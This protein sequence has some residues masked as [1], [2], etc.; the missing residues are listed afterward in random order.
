MINSVAVKVNKGLSTCLLIALI[1]ASS[2]TDAQNNGVKEPPTLTRILFL[3][4]ASNSMYGQWQSGVKIDVAKKLLGQLLDSIQ[5]I[6][7]LDL[8]LR[9]YGHQ[10]AVTPQDCDDTKLEVPFSKKNAQVI[11]KRLYEI[12]PKGTTPIARSLQAAANDFPDNKSRNIILLITD[13]IEACDGDPCAISAALQ[14]KGIFLKPFV[15]GLGLDANYMKGFDCIGSI[16]DAST[17][18]GFKNILNVI[19]SQALNATTLQINL[20]DINNKANETNLSMTFYDQSSGNIR[21]NFVHTM[22]DKGFPDTL[23]I[24][25]IPTYRIVVHSIPEVIK[26]NVKLLAG[27]HNTI[28]ISTPQGNLMLKTEG[29]GDFKKLPCIVKK[30][31]ECIQL[32]VQEF[33]SSE[34]YLVGKYDLDV[35]SLPRTL[36]KGIEI[37]QNH[38]T[39]VQ[40]PA[41][42]LAT[43]TTTNRGFGSLYV[44]D[45]TGLLWVTNLDENAINFN[46]SL[47]PGNYRVVFRSRTAKETI[48]TVEKS[49]KVVSGVSALI[50][51]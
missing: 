16:Y 38:T 35:L 48:Q 46:I 18:N 51:L 17:E 44:E 8:A 6:P 4:D 9:V 30:S 25:P 24:D 15:I 28:P 27:K 39:T 47:L 22:N 45:K 14:K 12:N 20:L 42:G 11:K 26:E 5:T 29:N 3:F 33:N 31:T 37:T 43:I 7:N 40:I 1:F 32:N 21:Y 41:P 2:F 13:G 19:I 36:I 34:K 10:K 49:F 23:K 50:K